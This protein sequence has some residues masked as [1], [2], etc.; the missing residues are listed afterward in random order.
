MSKEKSDFLVLKEMADKNM[1]V[2]VGTSLI[3]VRKVANGGHVVMGID[4]D[5]FDKIVDPV[6]IGQL[7]QTHYVMLVVVDKSQFHDIKKNHEAGV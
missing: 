5:T 7:T 1:D 4:G 3:G 2:R 6:K